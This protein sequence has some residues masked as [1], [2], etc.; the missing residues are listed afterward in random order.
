MVCLLLGDLL[1]HYLV[2]DCT[3]VTRQTML[4]N[5]HI[6][7]FTNLKQINHI[8]EGMYTFNLHPLRTSRADHNTEG[9]SISKSSRKALVI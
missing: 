2:V 5:D 9:F 8:Y 7:A 4:E 3:D 1:D 6:A